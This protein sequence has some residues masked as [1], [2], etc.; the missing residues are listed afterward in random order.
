MPHR[1][2][3]EPQPETA[4]RE[5]CPRCGDPLDAESLRRMRELC[6]RCRA[7]IANAAA[8]ERE[9][10]QAEP[11]PARDIAAPRKPRQP[12]RSC[13]DCGTPL[14]SPYV[15]A[16]ARRCQQCAPDWMVCGSC[17]ALRPVAEGCRTCRKARQRKRARA[18]SPRQGSRVA[19]THGAEDLDRPMRGLCIECWGELPAGRTHGHCD[20]CRT[21]RSRRTP[22]HQTTLPATFVR[23]GLPTLG[24]RSR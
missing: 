10:R 15:R 4:Q 14:P 18:Q 16:G 21:A 11:V 23:G 7:H 2:E 24:R 8:A 12:T 22:R 20:S 6:K 5:P 19:K 17:V 13:A 1:M 9:R 3:P